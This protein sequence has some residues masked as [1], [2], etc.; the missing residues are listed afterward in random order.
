M[1]ASILLPLCISLLLAFTLTS[2][3]SDVDLVLYKIKPSLQGSQPNIVLLSWNASVPL[4]QWRGLKWGFSDG[5]PLNCSSASPSSPLWSNATLYRNP[6]LN[7]V[8]LQLPSANLAGVLPR[9]V[10]EFA[11]LGKLYLAGNSLSGTVPV[12]L[13]YSSALSDVDLS[14]NSLQGPLPASIWNLC[15]GL[16]SLRLHGNELSGSVPDPVPDS[17]CGELRFLDLGQNS[18][19]GDFPEFVAGF[20]NLANLDLGGNSFSGRIP[21]SVAALTLRKLNVSHNNFSGPLPGDFERSGFGPEVFEGNDPTLCGLP[22]TPCPGRNSG[23]SSGAIAG[24]LIGLMTGTV[25]FFSVLIGYFQRRKRSSSN[26]NGGDEEEDEE[27]K[28]LFGETAGEQS[29]E[30]KLILFPGGEHLRLED[31]LNA[32]GQVIEKSNYGTVYKAKLGDGGTIALRLLKEDC[33]RPRSSFLPAVKQIGKIRHENL[34]PLKAFYEGKRGEK[35]LIHDYLPSRTLCD[36]LHEPMP[37]K[38]ALNWT[39]RRKIALGVAR[40]LAHLHGLDPPMAHGNVRSKTILVDDFFRARLNELGLDRITESHVGDELVSISKAE[41]YKAPELQSMRKCNPR[42]DVYAYG[43]VLLEILLGRR[44]GGG[45]SRNGK[46]YADLPALVKG[47][48]L[49]ETTVDV[50]DGEVVKGVRNPM[51]DGGLIQALRLAMGCCSPVAAVR[52]TM[53]EVV[54]QLEENRPNNRSDLYSPAETRS[55]SVTPF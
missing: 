48:V 11:N 51:E 37:G 27:E 54:R 18:F 8:S 33:C 21:A 41:G 44:P 39:R 15:S 55:G 25:V 3:V 17:N 4:C 14:F 45:C 29:D 9:E 47:A 7:L 16:V 34:I 53:E 35:L 38:P 23:L 31:I 12:E 32:T 26:P 46:E 40:G 30:G 13:G 20:R 19:A 28:E 24:L 2:S 6:E 50:F 36:L 49:E 10:G 22:L 42:S 43:I 52:P 5:S 1:A